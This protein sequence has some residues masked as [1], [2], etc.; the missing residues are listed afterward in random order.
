[1]PNANFFLVPTR[2]WE[3]LAGSLV[4]AGVGRSLSAHPARDVFAGAALLAIAACV[5]GYDDRLRYPGLYA[6]VPCLGAALLLATAGGATSR[7]GGWLSARPLVF[8]GLISYSLYLWHVPVLAFAGYY[9]V[10]PLGPWHVAA[11][12]AAIYLLSA[13]SWRYIEAPFRGRGSPV[14]DRAALRAAGAATLCVAA[15]GLTLWM[16][17]GWPAR[18]GTADTT[19]ISNLDRLQRDAVDC[20]VRPLGTIASGALCRYGP[21]DGAKADVVVWGDSHALALLPAYERIAAERNVRVHAAAHSACRPLLDATSRSE[22]PLRR[23]ACV[24]FNRAAVEAIDAIDPALV[25]LNAYWSYPDLDIA[26]S[27]DDASAN[28]TP[29]FEAAFERSLR[30]IDAGR[31]KIC[32]IGDVPT[33][34]YVMPYAYSMARRRGI[35]PGFVAPQS[36]EAYLE[37]RQLDGYLGELQGRHGFALV[38]LKGVL[39]QGPSCAVVT[40]D[41]RS[42]YRDNNHLSIAGAELVG[43][44]LE[45]CFD[46]I[47]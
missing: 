10:R 19:L 42:V 7:V 12:L 25:I 14:S 11:L 3:L 47:G 45:A 1:M 9:N 41:G 24:D 38:D 44:S 17:G 13:A 35:D 26:A 34:D 5:V 40:P 46:G 16:S 6:L 20:A 27:P 23:Q 28:G 37:H 33:L 21:S 32:V 2:A 29:P 8:T 15:L 18:L 22:T 31:R 43:G 39:C 30:A 4:A 36:A